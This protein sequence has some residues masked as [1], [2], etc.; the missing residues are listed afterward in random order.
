MGTAKTT[1]QVLQS[2]RDTLATAELGLSDIIQG[3]PERRLAGLRNLVVFGRAVTNVLQNL[4]S[5]EPEFDDWYSRYVIEMRE[6]PLLRYFYQVR[7]EILKEGTLRTGASVHL[8]RFIYP[9]DTQRSGPRPPGAR[10]FFMGDPYG[11]SGWEVQ[12]GD[13]KIERFYVDIPSDI[14]TIEVHLP[15]AP[16]LHLGKK[17]ADKRIETLAQLYYHY[18]AA[19]VEDAQRM[20]GKRRE[21]R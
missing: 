18:L 17:I 9:Y 4:R 12:L 19:M 16:D 20:F 7:S 13:G 21:E 5:I 2:S 11:R 8:N 14:A 1:A 10:A 3:G 15:D 6:D